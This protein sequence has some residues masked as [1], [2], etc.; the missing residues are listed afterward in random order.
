MA[1]AAESPLAGDAFYSR[2]PEYLGRLRLEGLAVGAE[3]ESRLFLLLSRLESAGAM[4]EAEGALAR[5]VVPVLA[6]TPAQQA[7]CHDHFRAMFSESNAVV[8][9][10]EG[11]PPSGDAEERKT[12]LRRI[13][14]SGATRA[15]SAL[16]IAVTIA[17]VVLAMQSID[18]PVNKPAN[19][20]S[21]SA[22][23]ID[24]NRLL[25]DW[26]RNFPIKEL[27]LPKQ[28]PWN[29]TLRW[30][31][32]EFGW[33]KSVVVA[34][35]WLVYAAAF[36]GLVYLTLAHL[37][38]ES[39]RQNLRTLP[40]SFRGDRPRF[41]DRALLTDLQSLRSLARD[42]IR[43]IDPE[44]MAI[45]T[46]EQGGLLTPRWRT[47]PVPADIVVLIDR[48]SPRD[49]LAS[50]G[51]AMVETLRNA[52]LFVEQF[53]F[54]RSPWTCRRRR[55]GEIKAL[56][57]VLGGFPG[58]IFLFF[59][60][61]SEFLNPG[62]GA[63][64]AWIAEIVDVARTFLVVPEE[65]SDMGPLGWALPKGLQI[66]HASAAG[67]RAVA[68]RLLAFEPPITA[69]AS[70]PALERMVARINER[71]DRWM[72][73]APPPSAEVDD[74]V[75]ELQQKAGSETYRW[76]SATSV[77]PEL[78]W[79]LTLYL[80]DRLGKRGGQP[81]TLAPDI[82]R[83][84]QLPWYRHGWM[85]D[86]M[87][88]RLLERLTAPER[89][90]VRALLLE[91]IGI[92]AAIRPSAAAMEVSAPKEA[93]AP[94]AERI[95]SDRILVDYLLPGLASTNQLFALP[96]EWAKKVARRPLRRLAVAAACGAVL[97]A[98]GS[99]GALA[100]MP[101]DDCDLWGTSQFQTD[102]I[103]P[104]LT[105]FLLDRGGYIGRVVAACKVATEREPDKPRFRYQYVRA[106][107][108]KPN[109]QAS[110]IEIVRT[111][112]FEL[113][114]I[115]YIAAIND[116]GYEY[117]TGIFDRDQLKAAKYFDIA[118]KLGSIEAGRNLAVVYQSSEFNSDYYHNERK[119][120]L[121]EYMDRGGATLGNYAYSFRDGEFGFEKD[122][123]KYC[124]I[125]KLGA[126]REDG[127]SAADV[128][129]FYQFGNICDGYP[130]DFYMANRY[131]L[132]G[133]EW[134]ANPYAAEKLA[135]NYLREQG[136]GKNVDQ[137]LYWAIFA[138]RLGN[139]EAVDLIYEIE[140]TTDQVKL[141]ELGLDLK[142]IVG[143]LKA[144]ADTGNEYSQYYL[145]QILESQGKI[146]EALVLY[147]NAADQGL[148]Q[149]TNALDR[150]ATRPG[151]Q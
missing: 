104:G 130:Q 79:L 50:Y 36:G 131:F 59:A 98:A 60:S 19:L 65:A 78:R 18:R 45:A 136:V 47:R 83:V 5:L 69:R 84:A 43:E 95:R 107:A 91:A 61:E 144:S 11:P 46:A 113:K 139:T 80:R 28:S 81:M 149:A 12:W 82:L 106:L 115:N 135:E 3:Q 128:G 55:S 8:D 48:R 126:D 29:R 93:G 127:D 108:S 42:E 92:T 120:L 35:P 17:V 99:F 22:V 21:G 132:K 103:G 148:Q 66:A 49:H 118:Y 7:M 27:E 109:I 151:I 10:K 75:A 97:A 14:R 71:A 9:G 62:S 63:P 58:A 41:G 145:G 142:L 140:A 110:E 20:T 25:L 102:A 54:D 96:E 89:R 23:A 32:T 125:Q 138:A 121:K 150:L 146:D 33:Q 147:R 86:W 15:V 44:A 133:I 24:A 74:F 123:Q 77:Y 26:I 64:K 100:V 56:S 6:G 114:K 73:G 105:S 2:L 1:G 117:H 53:D 38:R 141:A 119:R 143:Q 40:L 68:A 134:S 116:I 129:S 30:Y 57:S 37:R 39:L 34:L 87:R 31:Y 122:Q 124:E 76:I 67:L 111:V 137:A 101:I 70:A 13:L 94:P 16:V 4:P 85:P 51:E 52:G 88:S 90:K 72:Q 112:L